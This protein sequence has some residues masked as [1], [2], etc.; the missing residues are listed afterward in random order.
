MIYLMALQNR[1]LRNGRIKGFVNSF[2]T[3]AERNEGSL[4]A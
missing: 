2:D 1:E 3:G 4:S